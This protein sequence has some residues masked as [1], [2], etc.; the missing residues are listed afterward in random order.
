VGGS[1][2]G[3]GA[4]GGGG[5]GRG[6]GGK[7]PPHVGGWSV[8]EGAWRLVPDISLTT[9]LPFTR[10]R[11]GGDGEVFKALQREALED[12]VN[13]NT[14]GR[15]S[16]GVGRA[17]RA[18]G[19]SYGSKFHIVAIGGDDPHG[20]VVKWWGRFVR[21]AHRARVDFAD[22]KPPR[23]YRGDEE[24]LLDRPRRLDEEEEEKKQAETETKGEA[25]ACPPSET[26]DGMAKKTTIQLSD[27]LKNREWYLNKTVIRVHHPAFFPWAFS[28]D[29]T[30][31]IV[32]K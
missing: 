30:S 13:M 6:G 11:L 27:V 25:E 26:E 15:A 32:L 31:N 16:G 1:G 5:K 3:R 23:F 18:A 29:I 19:E 10:N 4:G 8:G 9:E 7:P 20:R 17:G 21:A 28:R 2:K 24:L 12:N 14:R 22:W